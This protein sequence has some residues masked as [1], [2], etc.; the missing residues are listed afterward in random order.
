M[1]APLDLGL[2]RLQRW[3]QAVIEQPGPVDEAV[4]S[5][6]ARA[7]LGPEDIERVVRPSKTLTPVERVGTVARTEPRQLPKTASKLPLAVLFGLM[8]I[9]LA[10]G[11]MVFGLRRDVAAV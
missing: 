3:M 7:E 5:P 10:V 2:P 4:V 1:P 8:S 9:G 11:L 6:A